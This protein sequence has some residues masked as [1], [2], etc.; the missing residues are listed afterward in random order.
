MRY[1]RTIAKTVST[2][3]CVAEIINALSNAKNS[4]V[5]NTAYDKNQLIGSPKNVSIQASFNDM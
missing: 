5:A 1:L 2:A 3:T 4:I